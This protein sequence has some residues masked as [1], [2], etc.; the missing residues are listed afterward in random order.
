MSTFVEN[1]PLAFGDDD[2][3]RNL[4]AVR[5]LL[6]G[7]RNKEIERRFSQLEDRLTASITALEDRLSRQFDDLEKGLRREIG[8]THER[9]EQTDA[10]TGSE[11]RRLG[12]LLNDRFSEVDENL[13]RVESEGRMLALERAKA[14][15]DEISDTVKQLR[16]EISEIGKSAAPR[17]ELG[18]RLVELGKFFSES[19]DDQKPLE[20]SGSAS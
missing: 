8:S 6:F 3:R 16:G 12:D 10:T 14:L 11:V 13:R 5:D 20:Q 7:S 1:S 2:A 9:I 18:R 4:D 19:G 17:D 15:K